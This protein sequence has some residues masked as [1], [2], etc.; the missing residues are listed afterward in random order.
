MVKVLA[1]D[2]FVDAL[3]EEDMRLRI[4]Q[5]KPA[6]LRG[7]LG[8][9]LELESYQ[10]ASRQKARFARQAQVDDAYAVQQQVSIQGTKEPVGDVLQR[11][12]DAPRQCTKESDRPRGTYSFR[13][14]NSRPGQSGRTNLVCWECKERGHRRRECPKLRASEGKVSHQGNEE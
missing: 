11:L 13:K 14:R 7:A 1:K 9:A 4:R 8:T 12:V 5:N 6:T 2:Q 10:L 3:P